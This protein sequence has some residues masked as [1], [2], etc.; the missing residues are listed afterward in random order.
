MA[1]IRSV[2][3]GFLT[4]EAAMS[5]AIEAPLALTLAIGLW[6]EADDCGTFEW[7]PLTLKAK[8]LPAIGADAMSNLLAILQR[9]DID[10]VKRFEID[11]KPYGVVRNFVRYQRPKSPKRFHPVTAD[12]MAYAGFNPDGSRPRSE[13]GGPSTGGSSEPDELKT[14]KSSELVPNDTRT[15]SEIPPQ[16]EDGGEGEGGRE[17]RSKPP[18]IA[19]SA[20]PKQ[21]RSKPKTPIAEDAQP[22]PLDL[23]AAQREGMTDATLRHEWRQFRAHHIA[24]GSVF[25]NW[26]Q[27][28][29]TWLGN[30]VS[31]G[32]KQIGT[33]DARAGPNGH[34]RPLTMT[35]LAF[36]DLP[37]DQ[38]TD[39]EPPAESARATD[40]AVPGFVG[41][42]SEPVRD[43]ASGKLLDLGPADADR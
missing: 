17:D 3:P 28:W 14:P 30:W 12:S 18:E 34:R 41:R 43:H 27:A 25:S 38:R 42:L 24:K 35:E 10:M 20:L 2:H 23:E 26:R 32:R 36:S 31:F 13:L 33:G 15:S 21:R 37:H 22:E 16:M 29:L 40:P 11:G 1:R 9:D 19:G 4:D 7:K 6:M 5:L 8:V 39:H